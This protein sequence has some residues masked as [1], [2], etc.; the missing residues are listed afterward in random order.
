MVDTSVQDAVANVAAQTT[1]VNAANQAAGADQTADAQPVLPVSSSA[2]S[3]VARTP[4]KNSH[5]VTLESSIR[6]SLY[7]GGSLSAPTMSI[8]AVKADV[9]RALRFDPSNVN[10]QAAQVSLSSE[11]PDTTTAQ[12][13]LQIAYSMI[14][15]KAPKSLSRM[16]MPQP[17]VPPTAD[18]TATQTTTQT[19]IIPQNNSINAVL[20]RS[21]ATVQGLSSQKSVGNMLSSNKK[22]TL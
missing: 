14:G 8:N 7:G 20:N 10:L 13:S 12:S 3:M 22:I 5:A 21:V 16:V 11:P 18:D 1:Q 4:R 19:T 17:P 2:Q 6:N 15:G 9:R